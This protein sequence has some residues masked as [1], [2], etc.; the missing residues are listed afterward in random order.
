MDDPACAEGQ[1]V[2]AL[3]FPMVKITSDLA[4]GAPGFGAGGKKSVNSTDDLS[5]LPIC[6]TTWDAATA[7]W[8]KIVAATA[9]KSIGAMMVP[10]SLL[11]IYPHIN[12]QAG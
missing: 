11:M 8:P 1:S 4:C 6:H 3:L 9:V 7:Y 12:R 5:N 2:S 10:V